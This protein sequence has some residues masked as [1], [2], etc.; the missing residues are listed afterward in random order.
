MNVLM[1]V[2]ISQ[3]IENKVRMSVINKVN[4]LMKFISFFINLKKILKKCRIICVMTT[5]TTVISLSKLNISEHICL[6]VKWNILK[7]TKKIIYRSQTS[8]SVGKDFIFINMYMYLLTR[9]ILNP[10]FV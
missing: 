10:I 3:L 7:K 9:S 1:N 8:Y 2:M 5:I 4:I 6:F